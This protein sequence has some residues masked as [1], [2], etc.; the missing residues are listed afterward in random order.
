MVCDKRPL[1]VQPSYHVHVD[2]CFRLI[3]IDEGIEWQVNIT[4]ICTLIVKYVVEHVKK[5][6]LFSITYY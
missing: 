2:S 4:H 1:R 6:I 5:I 3:D